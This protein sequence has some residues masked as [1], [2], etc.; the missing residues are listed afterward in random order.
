MALP[1]S[2]F[3]GAYFPQTHQH[4]ES[5]STSASDSAGSSPTT[6][7]S[8]PDDSSVMEMSPGSSPESPLA[9]SSLDSSAMD[10]SSMATSHEHTLP[11]R[12]ATFFDLQRPQTPGK[13]PRNLKNLAVNTTG[14]SGAPR[15]IAT[16]LPNV[17]AAMSETALKTSEGSFS[18]PRSPPR[19][20]PSNL[21]LTIMT[22]A[23]NNST[24]NYLP[25]IV[26]PTPSSIRPELRHFQSSPHLALSG[27]KE[28]SASASSV[29]T[30]GRPTPLTRSMSEQ[31][32]GNDDED[33]YDVPQSREAKPEAYPLGP[34]CVFEP[35][36]DLYLEPTAE[37]A[38]DYDVILNVA[39]E[40]RNPFIQMNVPIAPEPDLR[41][42][43][44]GG[45]QYAPR[46]DRNASHAGLSTSL[47]TVVEAP[48]PTTPKATTAEEA[49]APADSSEKEPEYI[50]VP[51]EHNTDIVPDLLRLVKL[52]DDRVRG[53]KR[54]L[55]HCQCGVSRSATLVVAYCMYKSPQM[56]VQQAYDTVKEKSKW[57][58]PNMNLIMQL[59]E[60]RS[61]LMGNPRRNF[62]FK[63][64]TPIEAPSN[65]NEWRKNNTLD[66]Q[67]EAKTPK[68]AP[69]PPKDGVATLSDDYNARPV[70]PGP[71]SA[72]SG[73]IWPSSDIR[74]E[75]AR[76]ERAQSVPQAS[77][78]N[79]GFVSPTNLQV[80]GGKRRPHSLRFETGSGS[81]DPET[82]K[83]SATSPRS[84]HFA[85]APLQPS[86]AVAPEDHFGLMSPSTTEFHHSPLDRA[87]LLGSLGMG[88]SMAEDTTRTR[89]QNF[90][91]PQR[92]SIAPTK[93]LP[94]AS[95]FAPAREASTSPATTVIEMVR[96]PDGN[97][98][99]FSVLMSPRATEFTMNP[100]DVMPSE[101]KMTNDL[102]VSDDDPRSPPQRGASPIN[103]NIATFL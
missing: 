41:L 93:P 90:S 49:M 61:S 102:K 65:W 26:P 50:H 75:A 69:L 31:P 1:S 86:A 78:L 29:T 92:R 51:W 99:G 66:G 21:S 82:I 4:Q 52:I 87:A 24:S 77:P 74:T 18:R 39:S 19:R 25:Q 54:V 81:V 6:T 38:R 84:E 95:T 35:F 16:S 53:G 70:T 91:Y 63:S 23:R 15:A 96:P 103:R 20:K 64:L 57:I 32:K 101:N 9:K 43:G 2:T 47:K 5:T 83:D 13:R 59:Q 80:P 76:D 56:S 48:S 22:S 60:F 33:N 12:S 28:A 45:I 94:P 55:V 11:S 40:V 68:T 34:I 10:A 8:I 79:D 36:V 37:Q 44:G 27:D 72:P 67:L 62:G 97:E 30:S 85:M 42:D 46:R 88:A 89:Q 17:K 73:L 7:A 3:S 71:S 98:D 100:F 14:S 58:G